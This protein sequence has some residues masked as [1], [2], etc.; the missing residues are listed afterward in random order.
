M[1]HYD[2]EKSFMGIVK[3]VSGLTAQPIRFDRMKP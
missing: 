2:A 1:T 3:L